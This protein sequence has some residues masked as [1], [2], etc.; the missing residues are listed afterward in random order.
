MTPEAKSKLLRAAA[1]RNTDPTSFV[2]QSALREAEEV[3]HEAETIEV[4]E[5]DYTR[6]LALIESP[7]EPNGRLLAVARTLPKSL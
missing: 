7:P 6:I 4:S 3:I 5:R 1:L 2:T